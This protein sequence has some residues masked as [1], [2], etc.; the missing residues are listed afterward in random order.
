MEKISLICACKNREN[1]LKISLSSW[2]LK[3][4]I[5][6]IIIVDWSS[7]KCLDD[8]KNLDKRIKI[9]RV[10]NQKFFN[11][12][13]SL[14]LAISVA[15]YEC[16]LKM[17]CDYILNPYYNFFDL[18]KIDDNCFVSG[19]MD[20]SENKVAWNEYVRPLRGLLFCKKNN[21]NSIGGYNEEFKKNYGYDDSEIEKRLC[22][23]GLSKIKIKYDHTLIHL[24]HDDY[25]RYKNHENGQEIPKELVSEVELIKNGFVAGY[26]SEDKKKWLIDYKISQWHIWDNQNKYQNTTETKIINKTSWK[27]NTIDDQLSEAI[28]L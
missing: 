23:Y 2:I 9:V 10:N 1:S 25:L 22:N 26:E 14:N 13:Q 27:L 17:D 19:D 21:L 18:Y 5:S 12:Q 16:I 11:Q 8:L 6:E 4:E 28:M 24:P 15:S 20:E 3:E 7:D